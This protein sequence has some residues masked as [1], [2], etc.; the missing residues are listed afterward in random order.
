M[1]VEIKKADRKETER[2]SMKINGV[3][4]RKGKKWN[5]K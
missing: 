2:S 1:N 5:K 3:T 4:R